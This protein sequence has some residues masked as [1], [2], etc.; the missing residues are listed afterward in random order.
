MSSKKL[1]TAWKDAPYGSVACDY[2]MVRLRQ[3][4][5]AFSRGPFLM[6]EPS[7]LAVRLT[8]VDAENL[9]GLLKEWLQDIESNDV[10]D[11]GRE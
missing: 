10:E 7:H 2:G 9:I 6:I 4:S 11:A 5:S 3:A 1:F 8:A